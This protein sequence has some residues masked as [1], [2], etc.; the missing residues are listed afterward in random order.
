MKNYKYT[1]SVCG[2]YEF[3]KAPH[4]KCERNY[5]KEEKKL[6]YTITYG[7]VRKD[8]KSYCKLKKEKNE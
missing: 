2:E 5:D 6:D 8:L 3:G 7:D 4:C 1:C